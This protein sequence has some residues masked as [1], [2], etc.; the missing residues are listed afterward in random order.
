MSPVRIEKKRCV[1]GIKRIHYFPMF[2]IFN[3]K[4][5]IYMEKYYTIR[6]NLGPKHFYNG[7]GR[8]AGYSA[9]SLFDGE[10]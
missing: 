9:D 10:S 7:N 3:W 2:T 4:G 1:S 8:Q 5:R 6:G